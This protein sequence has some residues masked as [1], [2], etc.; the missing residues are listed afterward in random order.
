MLGVL[1]KCLRGAKLSRIRAV[2][3]FAPATMRHP[4]GITAILMAVASSPSSWASSRPVAAFQ[5]RADFVL[6]A[7]DD[8][9]PIRRHRDAPDIALM[10]PRLDALTQST[11]HLI[12]SELGLRPIRTLGST[13]VRSFSVWQGLQRQKRTNDDFVA[14]H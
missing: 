9:R 6:R 13:T 7:G 5:I 1:Y 3:S 8:A 11:P 2:L 10:A 12:K 4:S 14:V